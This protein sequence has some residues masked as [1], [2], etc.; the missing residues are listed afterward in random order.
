MT[1]GVQGN[2]FRHNLV[3][4]NPP[5]QV[6]VDHASTS[7]VDIKNTATAGANTFGGN[8]CLT[9]VN[10][11]CPALA[12]PNNT[13]LIDELQ[14]LGCGSY[15]PTPSCQLTVSQWNFYLT[16]DIDPSASLLVIGDGT[17]LMTVQQYVQGRLDAGI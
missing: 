12:P 7:G 15:P 9:G 11:P 6:S 10:A 4:G 1:A 3:V 13:L 2:I 14:S 17:Q 16:N 5:V 8:I